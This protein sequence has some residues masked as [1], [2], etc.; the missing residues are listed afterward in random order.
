MNLEEKRKQIDSIDDKIITLYAERMGIVKEIALEK[1]KANANVLDMS[2]EK[3][4]LSRVTKDLTPEIRVFAKQLFN[5]LFDT[6][7]AYQSRY[8]HTSSNVSIAIKEALTG[9]RP[10]FPAFAT[11]ACQGVKGAYSY[12]AAEKIFQL[13]DITYFKNFEGVFNAVQSGLCEYG[14]LP[15]ENSSVGSVNAVYDLMKKYKFY[16]VKGLKLHIRHSLLGNKGASIKDIKE[17]VSHEQA[18]NQCSEFVK[19]Y[20]GVKI[21]AFEN[22]A[23]AALYVSESGRKDIA[24]I[25]S[26][27]CAELYGL[28]VLESNIQNNDSNYTRFIC[29]SK[30]L[31]IFPHAG[32]ISIM[33]NLPNESGSLNKMLTKFTT[34]GLNLTKLESRPYPNTDFEFLFYFDFEADIEKEEV[35]NLIAELDNR[36][37]QFSFLGS[38]S[39]Q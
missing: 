8:L 11:V 35:I 36:S 9:A 1:A 25:S 30:K 34:L 24:A 37:E 39:E 15:I 17:I 5:T 4:I 29:I 18:L 12:L 20:P 22:T 13:S 21:T 16:I 14:V 6:S 19:K 3:E 7:K 26:P 32:K 38:Y 31:K 33:V 23:S 2:R 27:E 10:D 28:A